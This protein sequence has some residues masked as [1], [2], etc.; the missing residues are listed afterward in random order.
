MMTIQ[1]LME[2]VLKDN[3][4]KDYLMERMA[5][6]VSNE[7]HFRD[8]EGNLIKEEIRNLIKEEAKQIIKETI[9]DYQEMHPIKEQI[10]KTLKELNKQEIIN[11]LSN[12]F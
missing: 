5:S 12:K 7:Y 9:E 6:I 8:S 11:L 3:K 2:E 10:E 1:N 4:F